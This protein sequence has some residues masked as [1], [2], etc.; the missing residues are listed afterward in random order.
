MVFSKSGRTIFPLLP[1]YGAHDPNRADGRIIPINPDGITPYLG[2]RSRLSQVW[3]NRW[4]VLLLLILARV[5]IAVSGLDSDMGSAKREA[6]SACTSVESMGSSMASMPHYLSRGVNELAASGVET[7]VHGLKSMLM[8][9]L[10]GVEEIIIFVINMMYQTYMCLITMAVRGSV[11][12][13]VGILEDAA[14][15]LNSTVKTIGHGINDT[16]ETFENN[17]NSFLGSINSAASASGGSFPKLNI[18]GPLEVL[19]NAQLPSSVDQ[20]LDKLNS[21]LPTFNDVSNFTQNVLR[22]PFEEV[23]KLINESLGDYTFNRSTL[24]VPAREQMTFCD[25]ND[26]INSFFNGISDISHTAKKVFIALL[27]IAA[28]LV[29][30][31]VAWS[32]LRRWRSMK[33]RSQ[34]VG[35]EAHDPMDVVYIVSRP[36]TAGAGIA[37]ASRFSN[38]RRQIL[39]RWV[40]AYATSPPALFVLCLGLAGLFSCLCQFILLRA[41]QKTVPELTSEVGDFADK[42]VAKLQNTSE[43]W[44]DGA[45]GAIEHVNN[46]INSD[47]FGWVNTSTTAVNDTLNTFVDKTTDV[48][49]QTFGG[50]LLYEP[51]MDVFECLVGLKVAGVQKGLTW[52]HDHAHI[53]FP[54]LPNDTFSLG[55]QESISDDSSKDGGG[56]FLASPA[57]ETSNKITE[58]VVRAIHKIEEGIRTEAIISGVICLVWVL[59][60]LM[61]ITRALTL[62]FFTREKN[63]GEGG[64]VPSMNLHGPVGAGVG[65]DG[66]FDVPLTAM[67]KTDTQ[68]P[69]QPA[70]RY[71]AATRGTAG[72]GATPHVSDADDYRF[73]DEKLGFTGS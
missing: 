38:S 27:V 23:K 15:F 12:V 63:R 67:P 57:D 52:V 49:N 56:N 8:L 54:L 73:A 55:A 18:S 29:C 48:L 65:P 30:I 46:N 11:H 9:T 47:V 3:L 2:I 69:S 72:A 42:V 53:D 40:I 64:G 39:V 45:N 58:V 16:V 14:D 44:A 6:L 68:Q 5:L 60:V 1:P 61:G 59:V 26:G 43:A 70:P 10:T 51:V 36:Y 25:G 20:G 13:A 34:L 4:T 71:E 24:P 22:F 31:P 37:A 28:I 7:A 35:K 66:F 17:L 19:E 33:D 62:F 50:T 21:T 41:V 32:E